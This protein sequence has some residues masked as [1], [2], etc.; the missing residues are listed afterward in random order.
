MT[1]I[2]RLAEQISLS[3]GD[4]FISSVEDDVKGE[5]RANV[6]DGLFAVARSIE[7]LARHLERVYVEVYAKN[8]EES[9]DGIAGS[10]S[11]IAQ[12]VTPKDQD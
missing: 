4:A 8:I 3:L 7:F 1:D 12:A 6:V 9:L 11:E 10:I 2:E 5:G